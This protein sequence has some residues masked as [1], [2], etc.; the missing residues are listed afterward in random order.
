[1]PL[2]KTRPVSSSGS[3]QTASPGARSH[4]RR[5]DRD[6]QRNV[7]RISH[8]ARTVE[9]E[10]KKANRRSGAAV[11]NRRPDPHVANRRRYD[12]CLSTEWRRA[13]REKS[14]LS[15]LLLDVDWFK[16]YNDTV[17]ASARRQLS[18]A[19]LQKLHRTLCSGPATWWR[20]SA[21]RSLPSFFLL[22]LRPAPLRSQNKS[23]RRCG[24]EDFPITPI[25]SAASRSRSVA[26][27]SSPVAWRAPL[28][29]DA[30]RR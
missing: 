10:L 13:L 29:P 23:A 28:N 19:E 1:M 6:P 9:L 5:G 11:A 25:R 3:R 26:R 2:E 14:P 4:H 16:S 7:A 12:Q 27:P 20:A 24:T 17:R 21:A 18:K 15:L 30:T 8:G 22:R